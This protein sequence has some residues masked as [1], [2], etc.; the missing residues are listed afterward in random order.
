MPLSCASVL[1]MNMG[2]HTHNVRAGVHVGHVHAALAVMIHAVH[3][4]PHNIDMECGRPNKAP[5]IC[6]IRRRCE[7]TQHH[8]AGLWLGAAQDRP[9]RTQAVARTHGVHPP[10]YTHKPPGVRRALP[11]T[12]THTSD[13]H[14]S[15]PSQPSRPRRPSGCSFRARAAAQ[16]LDQRRRASIARSSCRH[17]AGG[18][19]Q[20]MHAAR[21][22][23]H[24]Q[25]KVRRA[26]DRSAEAGG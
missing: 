15:G 17:G 4:G 14:S 10:P 3:R 22:G 23:P 21:A 26:P 20:C 18:L 8:P 16:P 24:Y 25:D 2:T 9:A 11:H 5:H 6:T 12:H 7:R 1:F 19:K 13:R